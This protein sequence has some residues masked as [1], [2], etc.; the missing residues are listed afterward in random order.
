MGLF[1]QKK[2]QHKRPSIDETADG[3]Q[4]FFDGYFSELRNRGKLEFERSLEQSTSEFKHDLDATVEKAN[5]ELRKHIASRLEEQYIENNKTMEAAQD[6]TL[7]VLKKTTASIQE[8]HHELST[9]LQRETA[10]QRT[11]LQGI[12][13][14][15]KSQVDSMR[16]AHDDALTALQESVQALQTQHQQMSELLHT[17]L[18]DQ[19]ARLISTFEDNMAQIIEHYV[20]GALGD[21]FDLKAQLPSIIKQMEQHKQEIVDDMKL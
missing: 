21:S 4:R 10:E 12:L 6:E 11:L 7:D 1:Q 19:E 15:N 14:E 18:I 8:Q 5:L 3:V 13:E 17:T 20:V 9:A 16:T 2:P